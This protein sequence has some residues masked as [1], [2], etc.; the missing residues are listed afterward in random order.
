MRQKRLLLVQNC[1]FSEFLFVTLFQLRDFSIVFFTLLGLI[2]CR[3]VSFYGGNCDT[4]DPVSLLVARKGKP[5]L[6]IFDK[7]SWPKNKR[8]F[9][10]RRMRMRERGGQFG[11]DGSK[12]L[13]R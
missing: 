2:I 6:S 7:L 4:T 13:G 9:C 5:S 8:R 1:L 3:K 10:H 11:S 12:D